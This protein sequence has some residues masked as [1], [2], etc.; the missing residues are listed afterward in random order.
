MKPEHVRASIV[1]AQSAWALLL[2][3]PWPSQIDFW[4]RHRWHER[5]TIL[6]DESFLRLIDDVLTAISD[7]NEYV[8]PKG[9]ISEKPIVELSRKEIDFIQKLRSEWRY[10]LETVAERIGSESAP[11]YL[12]DAEDLTSD[13]ALPAYVENTQFEFPDPAGTMMEALYEAGC[14]FDRDTGDQEWGNPKFERA[15]RF[16]ERL[17]FDPESWWRRERLLKPFIIDPQYIG[18]ENEDAVPRLVA[19]FVEY[20][21]VFVFGYFRACNALARSIIEC[22]IVE[23][24]PDNLKGLRSKGYVIW[25]HTFESLSGATALG[26]LGKKCEDFWEGRSAYIHYRSQVTAMEQE[27]EYKDIHETLRSLVY[28]L[29]KNSRRMKQ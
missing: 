11:T 25:K 24:F 6:P 12:L 23:L 13:S 28:A 20:Q 10:K 7:Y 17:P 1:R 14:K 16:L 9:G 4:F 22:C 29:F 15:F 27:L 26:E 8:L 3:E 21:R 18:A 19:L 5:P 2:Q